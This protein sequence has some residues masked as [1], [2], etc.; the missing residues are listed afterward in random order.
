AHVHHRRAH[1]P[2]EKPERLEEAVE[3]R[4]AADDRER[5]GDLA[6]ARI[7]RAYVD[8]SLRHG[9]TLPPEDRIRWRPRPY[10]GSIGKTPSQG[11]VG[12][13][14]PRKPSRGRA[15]AA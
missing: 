5:A 11:A 10:P 8:P 4:E 13:R 2:G 14:P 12:G 15:A 6:G 9:G 7:E 1:D 3:R